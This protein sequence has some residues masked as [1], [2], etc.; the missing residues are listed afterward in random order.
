MLNIGLFALCKF[1]FP[2][3]VESPEPFIIKGLLASVSS[4]IIKSSL[5]PTYWIQ[6]WELV[7]LV[8][9]NT[10]E[11]ELVMVTSSVTVTPVLVVSS[12]LTCSL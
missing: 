2:A 7:V 4:L 12:F 1:T 6:L 8:N 3:K 10:G 11:L 5:L 9:L